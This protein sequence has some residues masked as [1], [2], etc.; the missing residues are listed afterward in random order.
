MT[1]LIALL[2]LMAFG[3]QLP[4]AP[5]AAVQPVE[6]VA[7]TSGRLL[8]PDLI[9]W[10]EL[11]PDADAAA[12]YARVSSADFAPLPQG[13]ANFGFKSGAHWFA[14]TL[15]NH[16]PADA[17]WLLVVE[18]P[19]LDRIDL[20]VRYPDGHVAHQLGG[21]HLPF[22]ARPVDYRYP[23]F[24]V[25]LPHG[26]AVELLIRVE[27]GSSIQMPLMLYSPEAFANSAAGD[28]LAAGIYYGCVLAMLLFNL[29]LWLGLR[30]LG[31]LWYAFSLCGAGM[32]VLSLYGVGFQFLWPD[33]LWWQ[34]RAPAISACLAH[35]TVNQFNRNFLDLHQRWRLGDQISAGV[36]VGFLVLMLAFVWLPSH[37]SY[38]IVT[39]LAL[40]SSLWL[41]LVNVKVLRSGYK[42]A[43]YSLLAWIALLAGAVSYPLFAMGILPRNLLSYYGGQIGSGLEMILLAIALSYRYAALRNENERVVRDA[44]EQLEDRVEQRTRELQSA[45]LELKSTHAQLTE[46]HSQLVEAQQQLVLS[47]KMASLGTLT[48]GVAHEIN[49]P[50]NFADVAV[51]QLDQ[52]HAAFREFL[53]Q[54]A[55]DDADAEVIEAFDKHFQGFNE[56]TA[57]AHEGHSRIKT[58][59]LDLRQFSRLDEAERK[60]VPISEPIVSTVN[61]VRTRFGDIHFD[62]DLAYNPSI[63]CHAAKLGQVYMNLIVNACQAIGDCGDGRDGVIRIRSSLDGTQVRIDLSDNGMG[64][65]EAT[66]VRVFE[67]FFTTKDVGSGTGLGLSIVFGIIRD[68]RGSIDVASTPGVGTTFTLRLPVG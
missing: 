63:E 19:L 41:L 48:A 45:N 52:R 16:D 1:L 23:N 68:H 9:Y 28:H 5:A 4:A 39:A 60:A 54:L 18:S 53:Q 2:L 66:R 20:Y 33:G 57:L 50:A 44:N 55:G 46:A 30:D 7:S 32:A 29:L 43:R 59:V 56:M 12:A 6:L 42:P 62:L 3:A 10:H 38:R 65:D 64:M 27:S 35:L 37:T 17:R 25:D 51:Q 49:N 36:V 61:L 13:R 58:I 31:Y 26:Q 21:D 15:R 34:E 67:P 40:P 24:W 8:T 22:A 14:T 47:E 11:E